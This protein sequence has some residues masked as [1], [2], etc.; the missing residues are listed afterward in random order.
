MARSD[1]LALSQI[2]VYTARL[3]ILGYSASRGVT[4]PQLSLVGAAYFA[5]PRRDDRD[6]NDDD[7]R[8]YFDVAYNVR[9]LQRYVTINNS[10]VT[11]STGPD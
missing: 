4:A 8:M 5:Y 3:I 10:K 11:Y 1:S 6:D 9:K 2:R 7:E